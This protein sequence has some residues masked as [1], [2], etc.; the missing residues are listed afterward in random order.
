M[1][2]II[3]KQIQLH[4]LRFIVVGPTPRV[5]TNSVKFYLKIYKF[6]TGKLIEFNKTLNWL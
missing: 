5:P 4:I 2:N 6:N 3:Y 1:Y